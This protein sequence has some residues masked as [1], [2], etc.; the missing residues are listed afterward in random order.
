MAIA[1]LGAPLSLWGASALDLPGSPL[2]L[3]IPASCTVAFVI[4][5]LS[6]AGKR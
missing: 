2:Q 1:G 4:L 5:V 6:G 3:W